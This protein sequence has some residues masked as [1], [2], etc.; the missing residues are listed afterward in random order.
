MYFKYR[1]TLHTPQKWK[2]LGNEKYSIFFAGSVSKH[3]HKH[4]ELF[5]DVMCMCFAVFFCCKNDFHD[6]QMRASW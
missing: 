4:Y 2:N 3:K 5:P 1:N 6:E